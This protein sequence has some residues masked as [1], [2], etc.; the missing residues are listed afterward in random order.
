MF[1]SYNLHDFNVFFNFFERLFF[2]GTSFVFF[3]IF[4]LFA[5]VP[6]AP[7]DGAGVDIVASLHLA[8]GTVVSWFVLVV[9]LG[10]ALK[11]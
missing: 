11:K 10:F 6:V 2:F 5:A 3:L 7:F 4:K 9:S 8:D 1:K